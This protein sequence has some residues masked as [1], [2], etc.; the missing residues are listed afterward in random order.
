[1]HYYEFKT[2]YQSRLGLQK[3]GINIIPNAENFCYNPD[4]GTRN[5]RK[6]ANQFILRKISLKL[7]WRICC[8]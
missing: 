4:L 7:W 8:F 3:I 1:M 5:E 6:K 2:I